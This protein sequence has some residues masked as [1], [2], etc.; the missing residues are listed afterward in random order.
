[1]FVS[2]VLYSLGLAKEGG[3]FAYCPSWVNWFK[4]NDKWGTTPRPGA[5]VFFD[6]NNDN[7]AD[8]VGIVE[9]VSK[10]MVYTIE[11][12]RGDK[13][14]RQPRSPRDIQGYGYPWKEEDRAK[15]YTVKRGDTLSK[16]AFRHYSNSGKWKSIY[17]ANRQVIGDDPALIKAGQKLTLP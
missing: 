16:I 5:I 12:N 2:Y 6:W 3:Q 13:V 11:G 9:Y 1:M 14:S 10:G 4:R 8:H 7:L 17:M 15:V